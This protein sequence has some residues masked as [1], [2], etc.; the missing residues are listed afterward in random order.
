VRLLLLTCAVLFFASRGTNAAKHDETIYLDLS[1][2]AD[3]TL[4]GEEAYD[5]AGYSVSG[6]G[7]VDGDG[8]AD[9]L[10]GAY[11]NS[12]GGGSA[13]AAYL[14]RGPV[15]GTL[16]LSL[17]DA[18]LVGD[19]TSGYY[20]GWSVSGAGDVDG[21]GH[22]DLLIGAYLDEEGGAYQAGAAY[23]VRGPVSGTVALSA[24]DAKLLGEVE[25]D[26]AGW[27]V[28]GAGDVNH[29]GHADLLVGAP[30]HAYAGT[31][32][33]GAAYLLLGPVTGT[34]DLSLAEATFVGDTSECCSKA[35]YSV[36]GAGDVDGDGNDDFLI[37]M[38]G[39]GYPNYG[40]ILLFLGP[41]T[42]SLDSSTADAAL[43]GEGDSYGMGVGQSISGAGD[44]DADGHDDLLIG[45][46]YTGDVGEG[47]GYLVSGPV[48]GPQDLAEADA[49][50]VGHRNGDFAG[51]VSEAGDVDSDGFDDVLVGAPGSRQGRD[52]AAFVVRG[53]VKG[54]VEML[55]P[56]AP[57]YPRAPVR[58]GVTNRR[59]PDA[60]LAGDGFWDETG[61]SVSGAG[62]VDADG[63]DD[64][65][66]GA[67]ANNAGGSD[68]G[69]AYLV[70]GSSLF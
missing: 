22:D 9:L 41:V 28:S 51:I 34:V 4:V 10:L 68:A 42:G 13:G 3:A 38:P 32:Y 33:A 67:H 66:V 1:M 57:L 2:A 19:A 35:G 8:H 64:L 65:L 31:D 37:A 63:Q 11:D 12:E 69:A 61:W 60:V 27:S 24:A 29:D 59:F 18:K 45:A 14:V 49:K 55:H 54:T 70:Y 5:H 48:A 47:T 53:P 52:G 15:T 25:Y 7:D 6:A 21:D 23:L 20:A 40:V 50:F 39:A 16:D 26:R 58:A 56:D 30:N 36:S 62:D 46:P 17:A 43:W 44:V